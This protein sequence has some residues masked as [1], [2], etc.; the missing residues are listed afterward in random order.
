MGYS[1]YLTMITFVIY[2]I[3]FYFVVHLLNQF[4]YLQINEI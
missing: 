2:N 4:Y 1:L 3:Q